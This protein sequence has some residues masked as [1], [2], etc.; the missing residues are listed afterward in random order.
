MIKE[1]FDKIFEEQMKVWQ[2]YSKQGTIEWTWEIAAQDLQ[3]QM[4]SLTKRI[5]Q[6]QNKRYDDKLTKDEIKEH[7]ADELADIVAECLFIA[8]G[9][10]IDMG[11]AY[12]NM[13]ESDKKKISER[14]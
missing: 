6:L 9:L 3:Y 10:D 14:S 2:N 5:L 11:K 1:E 7:I 8:N 13:L 12:N 4:G